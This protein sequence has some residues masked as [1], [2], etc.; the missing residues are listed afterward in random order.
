MPKRR[1]LGGLR[2]TQRERPSAFGTAI[3][4]TRETSRADKRADCPHLDNRRVH[5][6]ALKISAAACLASDVRVRPEASA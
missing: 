2:Q 6:I 5:G 4:T 1:P 3:T